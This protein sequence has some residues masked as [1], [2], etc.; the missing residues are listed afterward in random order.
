MPFNP[1]TNATVP[2]FLLF[3]CQLARWIPFELKPE[4]SSV[5][6]DPEI[7]RA[8]SCLTTSVG[9]MPAKGD[10]APIAVLEK[11]PVGEAGLFFSFGRIGLG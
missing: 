7:G 6:P 10:L 9:S 4:T 3:W 1:L 11:Q 2:E 8:W 5:N